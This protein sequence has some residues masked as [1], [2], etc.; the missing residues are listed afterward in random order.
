MAELLGKKGEGVWIEA[1]FFCDFG[2]NIEIGENTFVNINCMFLDDN[3]IRIGRDGL[4][5]PYVQ[6]Y[7]AVHP[8]KASESIYHNETTTRFHTS[9]KPVI[10]GDQV[11]IGGN[12]VICPGVTIGHNVTISAG[13]V[14]T[15]DIPDNVLLGNPCRVVKSLE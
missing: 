14:V 9:T 12:A 6:I 8:L 4:I 5:A 11:W 10:I 13:S 1:P 15:K 2:K 7:T 3:L